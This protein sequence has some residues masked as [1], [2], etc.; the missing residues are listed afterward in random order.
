[1]RRRSEALVPEPCPTF[2]VVT[3]REFVVRRWAVSAAEHALLS[4]LIEGDTVGTAIERV[5]NRPD[6][7]CD[8]LGDILRGW[9]QHWSRAALFQSIQRP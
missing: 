6:V 1:V 5:A 3:R 4:A 9:F 7:N 2:L 8:G